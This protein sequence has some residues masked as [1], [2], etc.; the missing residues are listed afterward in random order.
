MPMVDAPRSLRLQR[1]FQLASPT[2][3]VG[4]FAYSEGLETAVALG[5][6]GDAGDVRAWLDGTLMH[7]FG[8]LDL[9]VMYRLYDAWRHQESM[10]AVRW[11]RYLMASRETAERR[12]QERHLGTALAALLHN[13]GIDAAQ[14]WRNG[15]AHAHIATFAA[16]FALAAEHWAI[17]AEDAAT[18]LTWAWL[19]NQVMAAVKLVPLGQ[20]Q[21]QELLLELAERVP[22]VLAGALRLGDDALAGALPG[23]TLMSTGHETLYSR[24]FRS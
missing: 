15:G 22:A 23:A 10:E 21:G 13:L 24:L 12:D 8:R 1:L 2:L 14:D 6:I 18:A 3:P 9:P 16:L 5:W 19:E 7:G 17:A 20:T 11:S 4:A